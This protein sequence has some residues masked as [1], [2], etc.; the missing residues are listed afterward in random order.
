LSANAVSASAP[1]PPS[2]PPS[3]PPVLP[4]QPGAS[5]A[6]RAVI[7]V[8]D[9]DAAMRDYLREELEHEGFRVEVAGSG[10]AGV[11]RVKQ[12]GIDLVV[13]DVKMPDLDGL[14]L[15]REVREVQPA[16][17]VITITAF[18]SIDTAIRAVKLGAFDYVTKPFEIEQLVLVIDKALSEQSLRS[19]VARLREEV[20]RSVR[21]ENIIGRSRAMQEVFALIRRVAGSQASV[22]ITGESGTGKELV[23]RA[24]HAHSPRA[25]HPF[26][27]VNCAAIPE[28][29]LESDLFGYKRG[30]FT[31]A[32]TDKAGLFVEANG[33]TI[34][35]DEIG[36]LPLTLQPKL[37]RALQERE[38]RPLGGTKSERVD[39]RLITATNRHLEKRLK[40]GRFRE[41]LFYRLN[42]IH[43]HLPPLRDR[44]EDVL[45]LAEHFLTRSAER[46]GK[47]LR[48]F[49]E[50][51]KKL[52]LAHAWPG[53]VRE[54]ENVVERA[55][56]LAEGD[57]V[58]PEDLPPA[59]RERK[60]Q[61]RLTS[62][63][64]QGLTLEELE[65]QYIQRVLEA[66]GGNKTRAAQ[67]LG[68]D[69]KTLYRKL[70]E[71][72]APS[73]GAA[74]GSSAPDDPDADES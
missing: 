69:R 57:I 35:L 49:K 17:Y 4:R 73:P 38:I 1:T 9:D 63:L 36:E 23:A 10:R 54:L 71:Y 24:L 42:V 7:L 8:V 20:A 34:F 11:E 31:D 64:M 59:L 68:L 12:G 13:S 28:T 5:P 58:T 56:A 46:A 72:A 39:I 29:L 52:L 53:N 44:A 6:A 25:N 26:V 66:E 67:R 43:I 2:T 47:P 3:T 30:A 21:F 41:D 61:D 32:K 55:V 50:T 14:D 74:E 15:L 60:S 22:L 65:R 33:G 48:S 51:A 18:G 27:A 37:L 62:A 45:P 40:E 16:P 70:E 19:E